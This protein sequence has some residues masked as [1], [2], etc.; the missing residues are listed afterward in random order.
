MGDVIY[1][2]ANDGICYSNTNCSAKSG[3]SINHSTHLC[4]FN[5]GI[6]T[7]YINK[8]MKQ[9]HNQTKSQ[10]NENITK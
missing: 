9:I 2:V 8:K 1:Y 4:V 6:Q 3:N 7:A 5:V 10:N